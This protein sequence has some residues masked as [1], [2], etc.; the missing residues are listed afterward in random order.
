MIRAS[1]KMLERSRKI[2][3]GE[4]KVIDVKMDVIGASAGDLSIDFFGE[5]FNVF[6]V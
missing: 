3:S 4:S 2:K 1:A 6:N 5:A